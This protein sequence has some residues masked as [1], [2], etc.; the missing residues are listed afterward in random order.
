ML[1]L[2]HHWSVM[3]LRI[4][5]P[6]M[7]R[8]FKICPS[9]SALDPAILGHRNTKITSARL[10]GKPNRQLTRVCMLSENKKKRLQ[11]F[12]LMLK[13]LSPC[14]DFTRSVKYHSKEES[15]ISNKIKVVLGGLFSWNTHNFYK[16]VIDYRLLII[17]LNEI[18]K[19]YLI[20]VSEKKRKCKGKSQS[21]KFEKK[22]GHISFKAGRETTKL[23]SLLI[24]RS[25]IKKFF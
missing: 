10:K 21:I 12:C 24:R 2:R 17:Y 3:N 5:T 14:C 19:R 11:C 25:F 15:C 7:D 13:I 4:Q 22:S 16:L 1:S 8:F 6:K 18:L 23:T 20:Y 9:K